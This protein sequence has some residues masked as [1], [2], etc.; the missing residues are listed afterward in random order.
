VEWLPW[1]QRLT[2]FPE[3]FGL[4]A[5]AHPVVFEYQGYRFAP[6]IC[7]EDTVPHLV[8]NIIHSTRPPSES[9]KANLDFLVNL[10]ND[11]WFHGSSELDQHLIT[12]AFRCVEYRTPLVRAVNTGISAFID[13]DG[14]IRKQATDINDLTSDAAKQ[15]EAVVVDAVP[16]DHRD[17][18][19]L[20]FGDW[21]GGL[22]L[23][24][25]FALGLVGVFGRWLPRRAGTPS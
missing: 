18:L 4:A 16:L 2:P 8:R 14:V 21:F 24:G 11:G 25:C 9:G 5:G 1:L 19:Y 13:G 22:C 3:G 15:V 20:R 6:V 12:A 17:S 23:A 7:Y 10:S